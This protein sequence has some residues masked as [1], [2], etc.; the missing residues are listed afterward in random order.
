[1]YLIKLWLVTVLLYGRIDR[2][3][4]RRQERTEKPFLDYIFLFNMQLFYFKERKLEGV[5]LPGLVY[6]A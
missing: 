5:T 2:G 6:T 4:G 1:M 3:G